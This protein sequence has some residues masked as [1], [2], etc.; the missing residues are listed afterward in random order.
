MRTTRTTRPP[1]LAASPAP[2]LIDDSHNAP[3]TTA[4]VVVGKL[5]HTARCALS[6]PVTTSGGWWAGEGSKTAGRKDDNSVLAC[7]HC[8]YFEKPCIAQTHPRNPHTTKACTSF[9]PP[10]HPWMTPTSN[11][12]RPSDDAAA[13]VPPLPPPSPPPAR[14]LL[15]S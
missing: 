10:T 6:V 2:L 7:F 12:I 8:V 13:A 4:V 5:Q 3:V 11:S 9:T 1:T 15:G 14:Q